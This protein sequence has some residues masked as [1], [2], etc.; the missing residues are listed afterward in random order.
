LEAWLRKPVLQAPSYS[1]MPVIEKRRY[2]VE[3]TLTF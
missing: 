1:V 3:F 2:G